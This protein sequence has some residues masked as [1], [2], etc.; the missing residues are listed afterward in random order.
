MEGNK[1]FILIVIVLLILAIGVVVVVVSL[2]SQPPLPPASDSTATTS[3]SQDL[4]ATPTPTP[5]STT[6]TPI[7]TTETEPESYTVEQ[8]AAELTDGFI[9][10]VCDGPTDP[11]GV[12]EVQG[13]CGICYTT[14]EGAD[15]YCEIESEYTAIV[16]ACPTQGIDCDFTDGDIVE[17]SV[18]ANVLVSRF[19]EEGCTVKLAVFTT[20]DFPTDE[21]TEEGLKNSL[22][23]IE[24]IDYLVYQN[25]DCSEFQVNDMADET[26]ATD[27]AETTDE[28][29]TANMSECGG[30]CE[31]DLDCAAGLTCDVTTNLCMS[32]ACI[33]SPN[34]GN[35]TGGCLTQ[36]TSK[37]GDACSTTE[38]CPVDHSCIEQKCVANFCLPDK[39]NDGC[40][41][42]E[43]AIISDEVD[44]LLL[45]VL[46]LIIG[47][48][49][50][51]T[52]A[53]MDL[54]YLFGGRNITSIWSDEEKEKLM[55][56]KRQSEIIQ[57]RYMAKKS[58]AQRKEFESKLR[59]S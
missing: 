46:V 10:N 22:K 14:N 11:N 49:V 13:E 31:S 24:P 6:P 38:D 43:T 56:E 25:A 44:R 30:S 8:T 36:V 7:P 15:G 37:C 16:L 5:I 17:T 9:T 27:T 34:S 54:F 18:N 2:L 45:G 26:D 41:L 21:T 47:V 33:D 35:C 59:S 23:N 48:L 3:T 40:T 4:A 58:E 12:G 51:K 19:A 32:P 55:E 57:K 39:C 20:A 29:D 53:H 28:T 1:K 50:Y 42:P 52:N